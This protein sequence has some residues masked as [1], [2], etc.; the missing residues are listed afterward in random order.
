MKCLQECIKKKK[1]CDQSECRHWID[2]KKDL[3]CVHQTVD[4]RGALTLRETAERLKLSFVRV[5]QI[6]DAALKK[7]IKRCLSAG[8]D[9]DQTKDILD[10]MAPNKSADFQ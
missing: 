2:Y 1:A 7:L 10:K 4:K 8:L 5:K 9:L 3:N 6:E